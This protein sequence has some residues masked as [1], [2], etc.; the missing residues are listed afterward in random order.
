MRERTRTVVVKRAVT[1]VQKPCAACGMLFW[2]AKVSKYCSR[3][4][5]NK[6]HYARHAAQYREE[7]RKRYVAQD[8]SKA[9]TGS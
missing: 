9:G 3:A 7:R 4:C 6:A 5:R 2:G 1:E 8:D